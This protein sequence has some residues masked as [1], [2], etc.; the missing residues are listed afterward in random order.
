ML[1]TVSSV[2]RV[3]AQPS[4]IG[5]SATPANGDDGN[6]DEHAVIVITTN[7]HCSSPT[8]NHRMSILPVCTPSAAC[9]C[10]T[11]SLPPPPDAVQPNRSGASAHSRSSIRCTTNNHCHPDPSRNPRPWRHVRAG[12]RH[13]MLRRRIP[14]SW[15]EPRPPIHLLKLSSPTSSPS[16]SP[17]FSPFFSPAF[18]HSF[19][20][21]TTSLTLPPTERP[22]P[23]PSPPE[24]PVPRPIRRL[25]GQARTPQLRRACPR[26][27]RHP[28]CL[29]H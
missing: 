14:L 6:D 28:R 15:T 7:T 23:Q 16:S 10:L 1:G 22:I 24:A 3:P 2:D 21:Y 27:Q 5:W 17:S 29:Q 13:G 11:L 25:V 20:T 8:P 19:G 18:S 12:P 26:R 4:R 9:S